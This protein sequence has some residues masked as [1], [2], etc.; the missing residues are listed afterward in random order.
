MAVEGTGVPPSTSRLEK[1]VCVVSALAGP[2]SPVLGAGDE[3][4]GAGEAWICRLEGSKWWDVLGLGEGRIVW[5]RR[6]NWRA[7]QV[8][9][10]VRIEAAISWMVGRF[11]RCEVRRWK[12]G[13]VVVKRF[14]YCSRSFR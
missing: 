8:G 4:A 2:R 14:R 11:G 10:G 7:W 5:G 6:W 13:I 3:S 1:S 12:G 9:V